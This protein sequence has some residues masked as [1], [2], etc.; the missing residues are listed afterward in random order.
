MV[1][2]NFDFVSVAV[3]KAKADA[4]LIVD[5]DRMPPGTIAAQRFQAVGRRQA[6]IVNSGCRIQLSQPHGGASHDI[7]RQPPGL[8]GGKKSLSLGI[9]ERPDHKSNIN[10][11]FMMSSVCLRKGLIAGVNSFYFLVRFGAAARFAATYAATLENVGARST[12]RR[13]ASG[14]ESPP[15]CA[16]DHLSIAASKC[17]CFVSQKPWCISRLRRYLAKSQSQA[18]APR[19]TIPS[20]ACD[21]LLACPRHYPQTYPQPRGIRASNPETRHD[22]LT[23][24][25]G[26]A[27]FPVRCVVLIRPET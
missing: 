16:A 21:P 18:I 24:T 5:P 19:K 9:G 3:G 25:V 27:R 12:R 7:S 14:R 11:M 17:L 20:Q 23:I 13:I 4:P 8:A 6:Q 15:S 1:I 10:K 22:A 2:D 26:A